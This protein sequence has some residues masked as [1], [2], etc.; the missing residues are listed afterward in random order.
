[1]NHIYEAPKLSI[2]LGSRQLKLYTLHLEQTETVSYRVALL[3]GQLKVNSYYLKQ[4]VFLLSVI[5]FSKH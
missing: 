3:L 4:I 2:L 1:M 5:D